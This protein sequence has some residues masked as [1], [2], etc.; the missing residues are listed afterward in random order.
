VKT[1]LF[2]VVYM[3][4]YIYTHSL[5]YVHIHIGGFIPLH[6]VRPSAWISRS[7]FWHAGAECAGA[8][9][10]PIQHLWYAVLV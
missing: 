3:Y 5:S 4:I 8:A 10:Q 7:V 9:L 2:I 1:V 6:D